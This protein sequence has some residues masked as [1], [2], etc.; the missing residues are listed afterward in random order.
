MLVVHQSLVSSMYMKQLLKHWL[1]RRGWGGGCK[2]EFLI[3][4]SLLNAVATFNFDCHFVSPNG[5]PPSL[6]L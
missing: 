2:V 5:D 4:Q 1:V 6:P 3:L